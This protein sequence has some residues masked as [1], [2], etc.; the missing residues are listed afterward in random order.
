MSTWPR[1]RRYFLFPVDFGWTYWRFS[2]NDSIKDPVVRPHFIKTCYPF[3]DSQT[4]DLQQI[5]HV[6]IFEDDV[7]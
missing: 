5:S 3:H 7:S 6:P 2:L 4:V 1:F